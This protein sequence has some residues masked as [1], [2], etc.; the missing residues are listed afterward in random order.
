[1]SA[2]PHL[3]RTDR[4]EVVTLSVG[5]LERIVEEAAARGHRQ[6]VEEALAASQLRDPVVR[7]RPIVAQP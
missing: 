1:M 4:V 3:P 2:G 5:D 7:T 6:T